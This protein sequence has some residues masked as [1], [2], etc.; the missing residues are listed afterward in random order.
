MGQKQ[1]AFHNYSNLLKFLRGKNETLENL[2]G[3]LLVAYLLVVQPVKYFPVISFLG[4]MSQM[5]H[6]DFFNIYF[7]VF[8]CVHMSHPHNLLSF[9]PKT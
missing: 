1:D 7:Y 6:T 8:Y 5:P 2:V 4:N 3:C 9:Y